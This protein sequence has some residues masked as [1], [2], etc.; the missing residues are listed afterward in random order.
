MAEKEV[1]EKGFGLSNLN[2]TV[3]ALVALVAI[4]GLT[5][6]VL[7]GRVSGPVGSGTLSV[8]SSGG[9]TN[10]GGEAI[11]FGHAAARAEIGGESR[12]TNCVDSGANCD[13]NACCSGTC[14]WSNGHYY[15]S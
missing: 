9:E 13:L 1:K 3:V 14:G 6:I 7:N 11:N 8:A 12:V 4:V 2:I 10:A 15:C 5:A